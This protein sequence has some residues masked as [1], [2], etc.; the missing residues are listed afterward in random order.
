MKI[1]I[2]HQTPFLLAHGGLQIQIERT[3]EALATSRIEV[4]HLRWWDDAQR[5][6]IIHFFGRAN[7]SHIDF[8]HAKG[9]K[10]VMS[11][12]LTGQGSR[13]PAQLR[14]Q[15]IIE[16]VLSKV[17]PATFL[18]NFR[19]GAYHKADA[20]IVGTP[21]EAEV[22]QLLFSPP[23]HKIHVV[24]NGVEEIFFVDSSTPLTRRKELVCTATITPRKRIVELTEAAIAAR[25]PLRIFGAPY[26]EGDP[27]YKLFLRTV[28]QAP[29]FISYE[30]PITDRAQLARIYQTARGFVLLSSMESR[31][32]SSEEAAAAGCPLLLSSLPWARS[33][34][35]GSATY[36]P[37]GNTQLTAT[38]LRKFYN[39]TSQL[40]KPPPPCRWSDVAT[41]LLHI[42]Q[43]I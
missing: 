5:G 41:H 20:L 14:L 2:D 7:P 21:W 9:M 17:V 39:E 8:A 3:K 38:V 25:T 4:E 27:Y 22:A 16:R 13:T 26:G 31:S 29:D 28:A 12:L 34:F 40:P 11:D 24:P 43:L 15:G 6:D 35:A 32:L 30:G 18:A 42:Y 37:I 1:L 33:T 19:W 23:Q 10:Y 36:C